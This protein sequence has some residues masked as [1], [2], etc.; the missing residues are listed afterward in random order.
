MPFSICRILMKWYD[1]NKRE[2][3]W[4]ETKDPYIIW[5]SEVILQQTRVEQGRGY[6]LDFVK[7]FPDVQSLASAS[8]DEVLKHWQGLG[9]Y[10]RARNLHHAAKDI[11][12]RFNGVFPEKYEDVLSLKGIGEYTAGAICSIS[13]NAPCIAVDG[14]VF[15]VL[16]RFFAIETPIDTGAG[17]KIFTETAKEIL[18]AEHPGEHNQALMEFGALQCVPQ[19]PDCSV[20][21]LNAECAAFLQNKVSDFPVKQ[22]KTVQKNRY[23]NYFYVCRDKCTFLSKRTGNDIWRGLYE[24]PLIET[25]HPTPI[26]TLSRSAEFESMFSKPVE[27]SIDSAFYCR[28]HVLSH[29][30]IYTHIYKVYIKGDNTYFSGLTKC[31]DGD[32]EP[33]PVSGLIHGYLNKECR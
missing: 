26:E 3:P 10:G 12:T 24:F 5:I 32:F 1:E 17:K 33:Y 7:R 8:E 19:S 9:Y 29:Q 15:R 23:F 30:I 14:N 31:Y 18:N 2:L 25:K 6:F 16:S 11:I 21:P 4:R 13:R 27:V 28:K 22:G 20:C